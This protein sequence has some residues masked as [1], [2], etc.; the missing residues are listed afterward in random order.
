M[1]ELKGL[2]AVPRIYMRYRIR[3]AHITHHWL[4]RTTPKQFARNGSHYNTTSTE[5][6][7]WSFK[8]KSKALDLL[9]K[10]IENQREHNKYLPEGMPKPLDPKTL[11][12]VEEYEDSDAPA[13]D[14]FNTGAFSV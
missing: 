6:A 7:A 14:T 4:A 11:Y 13:L 9:D 2:G 10:W 1:A 3:H 5:T 12:F 8:S